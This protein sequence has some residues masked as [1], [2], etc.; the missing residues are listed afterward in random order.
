VDALT[1]SCFRVLDVQCSLPLVLDL[2]MEDDALCV[3][4]TCAAFRDAIFGRYPRG[5]VYSC[6]TR[7]SSSPA[8]RLCTGVRGVLSSVRRA[9]WARGLPDCPP[10]LSRWDGRVCQYI[11]A[12]GTLEVLQAY[13]LQRHGAAITRCF[14]GRGFRDVRGIHARVMQ[15]RE[16][17]I[18]QCYSGRG[19]RAVPGIPARAVG[20]RQEGIWPYCSGRGKMGVTGIHIRLHLLQRMATWNCYSGPVQMGVHWMSMFAILLLA[21]GISIFCDGRRRRGASGR[22]QPAPLP[23][24]QVTFMCYNGCVYTVAIGT[25]AHALRQGTLST[26]NF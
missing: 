16:A 25:P 7:C 21:K 9:E 14:N 20:L 24:P 4:L 23:Q 11:A 19:P 1:N 13:A 22:Q 2:V 17:G 6:A 5:R 26:R 10:W 15:P 8:V 12:C 18:L 3:A